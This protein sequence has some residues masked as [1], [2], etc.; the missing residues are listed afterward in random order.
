MNAYAQKWQAKI[1]RRREVGGLDTKDH[2][3]QQNSGAEDR[4]SSL[5]VKLGGKSHIEAMP[6]QAHLQLQKLNRNPSLSLF[7]AA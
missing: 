7:H 5:S 6:L 4:Y 2:Q 3:E 1:Y